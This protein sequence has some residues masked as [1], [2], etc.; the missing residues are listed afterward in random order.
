MPGSHYPQKICTK[1]IF[2]SQMCHQPL[3]K[4]QNHFLSSIYSSAFNVCILWSNVMQVEIEYTHQFKVEIGQK[5]PTTVNWICLRWNISRHNFFVVILQHNFSWEMLQHVLKCHCLQQGI[6][7]NQLF[8][9]CV[10]EVTKTGYI[11][12]LNSIHHIRKSGPLQTTVPVV[13]TYR[14]VDEFGI[15]SF[16]WQCRGWPL[17]LSNTVYISF[18]IQTDPCIRYACACVK[19][20]TV[21]EDTV[22]G[23]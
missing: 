4:R 3:N 18:C 13:I 14:I 2:Q 21:L 20:E 12:D 5:M 6:N 7:V 19:R 1:T 22:V 23:A 10:F 16:P 9:T 17:L 11:P 15:Q 8:C